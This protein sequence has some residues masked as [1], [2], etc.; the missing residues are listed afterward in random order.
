MKISFKLIMQLKCRFVIKNNN[1]TPHGWNL[2][3]IDF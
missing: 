3:N 2:N 1:E